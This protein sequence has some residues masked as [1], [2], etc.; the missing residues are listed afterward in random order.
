MENKIKKIPLLRIA[1]YLPL[2]FISTLASLYIFLT[3]ANDYIA[4]IMVSTIIVVG[5]LFTFYPRKYSTTTQSN[6]MVN[7]IGTVIAIILISIVAFII[8]IGIE[9]S[10]ISG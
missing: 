9:I 6:P 2:T 7:F 3:L 4:A 5:L 1:I 10:N 8:R